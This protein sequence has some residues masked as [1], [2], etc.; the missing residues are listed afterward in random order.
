M[1]SWPA[2]A[3][4]VLESDLRHTPQPQAVT[5]LPAQETG[6]ALERLRSVAPGGL[7]AQCR[8]EDAGQL[9]VRA[10]VHLGER[11]ESHARVVHFAHEQIGQLVADLVTDTFGAGSL[12]HE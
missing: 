2:M 6:G 10:H 12:G 11:D 5:D 3:S 7:V 1:R 4:S 9:Q 8:V